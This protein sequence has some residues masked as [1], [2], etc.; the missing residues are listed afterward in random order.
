VRLL[1]RDDPLELVGTALLGEQIRRICA[2]QGQARLL[3]PSLSDGTAT[4]ESE[5]S[6]A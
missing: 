5:R 3:G 2:I 6:T 4:A 1:A